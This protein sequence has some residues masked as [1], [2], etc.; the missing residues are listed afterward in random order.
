MIFNMDK[1]NKIT[2]GQKVMVEQACKAQVVT[3]FAETEAKQ[4]AAMAFHES[5][6]VT[7]HRWSPEVL[8]EFEGAWKEVIAEEIKA[9]PE[10]AKIWASMSKFR[11]E[12][13]VW[14]KNG[15]L[16]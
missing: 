7:I 9:S 12:Y 10:A 3:S 1:F 2:D 4:G 15:Y 16:D 13:T 11:D 14:K 6:G 5:K 8:A